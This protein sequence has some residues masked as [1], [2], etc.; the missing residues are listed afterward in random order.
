[1]T[2]Q[3]LIHQFVSLIPDDLDEN[4]LYISMEYSTVAHKCACGCGEEVTIPL[5]PTDWKLEFDGATVTLWPSI[6]NWSFACRS[7]Y[8]IKSNRI[9]WDEKWSDEKIQHSRM[10]DKILKSDYYQNELSEDVIGYESDEIEVSVW[11]SFRRYF[12]WEYR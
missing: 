8:W 7:H 3:K 9:C 10:A 1:M 2:T 11:E 4:K 6:G 12:G 5:S